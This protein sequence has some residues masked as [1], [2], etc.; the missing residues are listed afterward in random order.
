MRVAAADLS[1]NGSL[2]INGVVISAANP[3]PSKE[4]LA[5]LVNAQTATTN[6]QAAI[7]P[8]DGAFVLTNIAGKEGNAIVLG[9]QPGVLSTYSGTVTPDR[10]LD[11]PWQAGQVSRSTIEVFGRR[12]A[13][14][15]V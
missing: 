14:T 15:A 13:A 3:V 8:E 4:D 7:D 6:V 1:T 5:A 2:T 12:F 10:Y 11:K 9:A